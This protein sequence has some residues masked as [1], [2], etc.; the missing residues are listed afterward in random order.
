MR[1][2]G[3]NDKDLVVSIL[4]KSFNNDP[5]IHFLLEKSRNNK[6]ME[7]IMD[8]VVDETLSK[9]EIHINEDNT[10]V[11]LWL[12]NKKEKFSL[13]FIQRNLT[14]LFRAGVAATVRSLK[15]EGLTNRLY[16]KK[17]NFKH[18]YLIGVLPEVQGKGNAKRLLS[19][20]INESEI[21]KVPLY[22]ETANLT[23]LTIYKR[24]G[25]SVFNRIEMNNHTL[26]CLNRIF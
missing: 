8:Y 22:L 11:A 25:F 21:T 19:T 20:M 23:N 5:H 2:A 14:F 16:P 6:K 3:E 1:K 18:L 10:A 17:S 12:S 9:G 4:T 15:T 24:L 26:F 7:I 13:R